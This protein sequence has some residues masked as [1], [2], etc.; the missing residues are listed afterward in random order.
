MSVDMRA[1]KVVGLSGIVGLLASHGVEGS[2]S[3]E[4]LVSAAMAAGHPPDKA[5][6]WLAEGVGCWCVGVPRL[7][8]STVAFQVEIT[9]AGGGFPLPLSVPQMIARGL[10]A[11][12]P[13]DTVRVELARRRTALVRIKLPDD[14]PESRWG[15]PPAALRMV[16]EAT[17]VRTLGELLGSGAGGE[18]PETWEAAD[19]LIHLGFIDLDESERP[20]LLEIPDEDATTFIPED[21]LS[22]YESRALFFEEDEDS[23]KDE[24]EAPKA[25][26]NSGEDDQLAEKRHRL[27]STLM[28]L[29]HI[30]PIELF[31]IET[32]EQAEREGVEVAFRKVSANYHPDRY[33]KDTAEIRGLASECF[34]RI[35]DARDQI[36]ADPAALEL[37]HL[38]LKAAESGEHFI[39]ASEAEQAHT[40]LKEL[41]RAA[42]RREWQLCLELAARVLT[43]DP[44]RWEA[45]FIQ[46]Q[47]RY[48]ARLIGP[49]QVVTELDAL[50]PSNKR[51]RAQI[52][53]YK[54]EV[55]LAD[56]KKSAAYASFRSAVAADETHT[57]AKRRLRLRELRESRQ[58]ESDQAGSVGEKLSRLF[59]RKK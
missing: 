35:A 42:Q 37:L 59:G 21:D 4:E 53:Y 45:A 5:L 27:Q 32:S 29:K 3:L 13:A 11:V 44:D 12:R 48:G 10:K 8:A 38:K 56:G 51:G 16:R 26:V 20:S 15:L 30:D 41:K 31:V 49:S 9:A 28:R 47:A 22:D 52:L 1:G 36:L 54:G 57:D 58:S 50:E 17:R 18:R 40:A 46:V 34:G 2:G 43:L 7:P 25:Q 6:T 33:A 24:A 39:S 19:L 55:Q 23:E 14:A